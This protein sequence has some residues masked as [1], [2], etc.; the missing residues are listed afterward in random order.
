MLDLT[1]L[2][3]K[4]LNF[5]Q[6]PFNFQIGSRASVSNDT[7]MLILPDLNLRFFLVDQLGQPFILI[8]QLRVMSQD[9]LYFV[10]QLGCL[11]HSCP[12]HSD[13]FDQGVVFLFQG[14]DEV[15][16]RLGDSGATGEAR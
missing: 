16:G 3:F 15:F 5:I 1:A 7:V 12:Q 10:F 8:Q 11:A 6:Q 14:S 4:F 13:L 9:Q 2:F